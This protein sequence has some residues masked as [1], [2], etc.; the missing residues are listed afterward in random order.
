MNAREDIEEIIG[1]ECYSY[2]GEDTDLP[3]MIAES[4]RNYMNHYGVVF[5][6]P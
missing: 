3:A 4:I 6:Q 2:F 5:Y 1:N